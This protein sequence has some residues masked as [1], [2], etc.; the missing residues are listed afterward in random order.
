MDCIRVREAIFL[1]TDNEL[2]EELFV[3]FREH[4]VDCPHCARKIDYTIKVLALVRKSC[5]GASAP[6]SLRQKI[7]TS[8]PHRRL[9]AHDR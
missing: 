4:L 7:L 9:G 3:A 6:E 5:A 2:E 1:Y 8:L